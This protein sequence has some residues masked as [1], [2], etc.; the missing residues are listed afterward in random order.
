MAHSGD[1]VSM[2]FIANPILAYKRALAM[3]DDEEKCT[4]TEEMAKNITRALTTQREVKNQLFV[5]LD[6]YQWDVGWFICTSAVRPFYCHAK[7][8]KTQW[9]APF[10]GCYSLGNIGDTIRRVCRRSTVGQWIHESLFALNLPSL[11]AVH[12]KFG[13]LAMDETAYRHILNRV[14]LSRERRALLITILHLDKDDHLV[15]MIKY[16]LW[17]I[18]NW[19]KELKKQKRLN[20]R[21]K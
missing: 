8:R 5:N 7:T 11:P 18:N 10:D 21:H 3:V 12:G 6:D 17:Y 14:Q 15:A 19:Y 2:G 4:F 20:G 1:D 9:E 13:E 16:C